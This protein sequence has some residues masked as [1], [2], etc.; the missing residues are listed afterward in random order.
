MVDGLH[1]HVWNRAVKPLAI[2]LRGEGRGLFRGD[3]GTI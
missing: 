1:I 3:Y 2:A